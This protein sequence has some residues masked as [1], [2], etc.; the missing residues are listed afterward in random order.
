[1][2]V[3]AGTANRAFAKGSRCPTRQ[4]TPLNRAPSLHP[5]DEPLLLCKTSLTPLIGRRPTVST[6]NRENLSRPSRAAGAPSRAPRTLLTS[7]AP[8]ALTCL[9]RAS[10]IS[11]PGARNLLS[12][13]GAHRLP[14]PCAAMRMSSTVR[15]ARRLLGAIT[16]LSD[17]NAV[18]T[19]WASCIRAPGARASRALML[20]GG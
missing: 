8:R 2:V 5:S 14:A 9:Y 16:M 13:E 7:G 12:A 17:D 15:D 20:T 10:C 1:M 4:A 19:C 3:E 18:R 11:L 6:P